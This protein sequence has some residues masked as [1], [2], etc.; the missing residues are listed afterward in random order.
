MDIGVPRDCCRILSVVSVFSRFSC[1][2]RLFSLD[3][4]ALSSKKPGLKIE[5]NALIIEVLRY[6]FF[7]CSVRTQNEL[8]RFWFFFLKIFELN[9]LYY[10]LMKFRSPFQLFF[11]HFLNMLF[12]VVGRCLC[13]LN[14][15]TTC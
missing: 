1:I 15:S 7:S 11:E 14:P 4:E 8:Y 3:S 9:I 5:G 12:R 2:F 6:F 13:W 10:F